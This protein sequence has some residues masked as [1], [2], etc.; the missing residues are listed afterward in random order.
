M[1]NSYI[2]DL[3]S[4]IVTNDF[5]YIT[6]AEATAQITQVSG[7]LSGNMGQLN[8]LLYTSFSAAELSKI[9]KVPT[10]SGNPWEQEEQAIYTQIYLQDYYGKQARMALRT[11]T[12]TASTTASGTFTMTPWT[13]LKEGDTTIQREAIKVTSSSRTAAARAFGDFAKAAEEKLQDLVYKYNFYQAHPRQVAGSDGFGP[14]GSY[15]G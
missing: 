9:P 1:A 10:V 4:G 3:A 15:Y 12:D 13:V 11:F 5:D 14:S 6:G 8:T 2:G 7:W